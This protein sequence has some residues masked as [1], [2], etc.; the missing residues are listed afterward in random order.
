MAPEED[1]MMKRMMMVRRRTI[2]VCGVCFSDQIA[3][4]VTM[5]LQVQSRLSRMLD[6]V[7]VSLR[8]TSTTSINKSTKLSLI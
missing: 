1:D 2:S 4:V 5:T 3:A 7:Q 6:Q 8:S